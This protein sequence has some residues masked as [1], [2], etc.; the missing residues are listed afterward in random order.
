VSV[1]ISYV[2]EQGRGGSISAVAD[3]SR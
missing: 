1:V 3:V 2:D